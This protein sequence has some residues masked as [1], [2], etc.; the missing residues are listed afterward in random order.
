[1]TQRILVSAKRASRNIIFFP[2][3]ARDPPSKGS[4][5]NTETMFMRR[6]EHP[7]RP[8]LRN[9]YAPTRVSFRLYARLS[10]TTRPPPASDTQSSHDCHSKSPKLRKRRYSFYCTLCAWR[11]IKDRPSQFPQNSFPRMR[12]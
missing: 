7:G 9:H 2:L 5:S 11:D 8:Q 10:G 4:N 6:G 3:V 1:M 12:S